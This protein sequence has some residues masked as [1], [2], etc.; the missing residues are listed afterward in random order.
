MRKMTWAKLLFLLVVFALATFGAVWCSGLFFF[1]L[2]KSNPLGKTDLLTWLNYWRYYQADP[3]IAMRLKK[4][5]IL[6]V[7]VSYSFPLVLVVAAFR[8]KR[9][10][11]GEARF[12]VASEIRRSGLLGTQHGIIV[13]RWKKQYLMLSGQQFVL[14]SA[15][16][17]SGKGVGIVI[18]N[19][20]NFTDSCVVLDIKQENFNL[21][22][23][24]REKHGQ[25]IYLFNP[26]SEDL[27]T[28]RYNPL[29]YIRDGNFRVGDILAI[30]KVFYP[31]DGKDPFFD[32][33][34]Q[35]LFLGLALYLCETQSLP[36]TIGEMLRQSSGKGQPL[37][38]YLHSI[39]KARNQDGQDIPAGQKQGNKGLPPLSMACVDA[40]NRFM[41]TSDNTLTSILATFNAPLTI[42]ANPIVDAATAENDFDMR[43]V[44]R[45]R[46]TIYVGI[47]PDH[48]QE[49]GRLVN[50]FF[51]QLVNLNTKELP[52]ASP[53]L[54][55]QCLLLLDE[56][57]SM[58]KVGIIA[59]AV[60]YLAAYN[61]RLLPIIQSISQ[62]TSVYGPE[63]A[64]NFITN[65]ALHILYAPR[66]QRDANEYS[67]MLGYE[68]VKSSSK[69]RQRGRTSS[70]SVSDQRRALLLPQ[71][72]K[73]IGQWKE[74]IILENTKPILCDKIKY[75]A[76]P[77]FKKRL[78]SAPVVQLLDLD[79]H[80]AMVQSRTRCMTV[81]DVKQEID[82]NKIALD[83]SKIPDLN[84]DELDQNAVEA[85]VNGFFDSFEIEEGD[86]DVASQDKPILDLSV[87]NR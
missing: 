74:I 59:K 55:Y 64:R 3:I 17:R 66:E 47:T 60:A 83:F 7:V 68:T 86:D 2:S 58:G 84:E 39:V 32:D 29:G 87:L 40:L 6:A 1:L 24:F 67:E 79:T 38:N 8:K 56:F 35:N 30:A 78:F 42:W 9:S 27:R 11:H 41:N 69:S 49:A 12:A 23:G 80:Q 26:F 10:L 14:L 4:A 85:L 43:D 37:R 44:R 57:T 54:K 77:I 28:H 51:S 73:E 50:L 65:H 71:E 82:L 70:E 46:M 48:L 31:G 81:E 21:T 53:D 63:D 33:Q 36:R 18:P 75:F 45:K 72:I 25:K 34:A 19:L 76:D 22:A 5:A 61:L 13:G 52:E 15:P 62:L 20:L 16:T